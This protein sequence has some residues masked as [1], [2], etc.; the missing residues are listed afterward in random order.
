MVS[1]AYLVFTFLA[2]VLGSGL[3]LV[4]F[5]ARQMRLAA[6]GRAAPDL[7][8]GNEEE[9]WDAIR[10]WQSHENRVFATCVSACAALPLAFA[11]AAWASRG[12]VVSAVCS[13]LTTVSMNSPLCF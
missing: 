2:C 6:A 5:R 11:A 10:R 12:D 3:G 9:R 4:M 7:T 8:I 13:G 1:V